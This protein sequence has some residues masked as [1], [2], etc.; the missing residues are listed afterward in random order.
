MTTVFE[1]A[2]MGDSPRSHSRSAQEP[3]ARDGLGHRLASA[4]LKAGSNYRVAAVL[5]ALGIGGVVLLLVL[6]VPGTG[7]GIA[8]TTALALLTVLLVSSGVSAIRDGIAV[9][10]RSVHTHEHGLLVETNDG[11]LLLPYADLVVYR[12]QIDHKKGATT[13]YT[14]VT[15]RIE[16]RDGT[17]WQCNAESIGLD[18][19]F[20]STLA[21]ACE[22]QAAP[23]AAA[24]ASGS[25][26]TY[27][28]VSFDGHR[29]RAPGLDVTWTDVK[30]VTVTKGRVA[31]WI[32][33][34]GRLVKELWQ[35]VGAA[36]KIPNFPLFW[37]LFQRAFANSRPGTSATASPTPA[38][39]ATSASGEVHAPAVPDGPAS[40]TSGSSGS[41]SPGGRS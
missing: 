29:L 25:T 24:L 8:G 16:R 14:T 3:A 19:L 12:E 35:P 30:D 13:M 37:S 33:R 36:G 31:V 17:T 5:L 32:P 9:R 2:T 10:G 28:D 20:E 6:G 18:E 15:F 34:D 40:P 39:P 22:V 7:G 27:G 4:P 21:K 11:P 26:L 1:G 41:D 23:Q 38:G